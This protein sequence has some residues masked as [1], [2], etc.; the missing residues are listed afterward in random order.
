M[1]P[2]KGSW[3]MT[4]HKVFEPANPYKMFVVNLCP[5]WDDRRRIEELVDKWD[6]MGVWFMMI[7]DSC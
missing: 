4:Q 5:N 2:T 6:E 1:D 3:N 7:E